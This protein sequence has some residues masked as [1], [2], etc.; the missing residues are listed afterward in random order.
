MTCSTWGITARAIAC[1]CFVAAMMWAAW[2]AKAQPS[3]VPTKEL[4]ERLA[5]NGDVTVSYNAS[6][7]VAY[8]KAINEQSAGV[9]GILIF[10]MGTIA[11]SA[12]FIRVDDCIDGSVIVSRD[13]HLDALAKARGI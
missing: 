8:A 2:P 5:E 9:I 7:A 1:A 4:A 11:I 12:S 3:C 13:L 10:D 6:I